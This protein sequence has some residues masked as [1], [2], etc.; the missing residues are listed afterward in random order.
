MLSMRIALAAIAV[1]MLSACSST[2]LASTWFAPDDPR[3]PMRNLA[4]FVALKDTDTARFI[5][6]ELSR[7]PPQGVA[8]TAGHT[9]AVNPGMPSDEARTA[10]A[11][12]GFEGAIVTRLVT[13][14]ERDVYHPPE[15]NFAGD[16][17][18][19]AP[20]YRSFWGYYPYAYATLVTPGYVS[21]ERR[22]IVET[23]LYRLP[24]GKP[25]WSAVT[26]S[27]N[28]AS[29]LVMINEVRAIATKQLRTAGLIPPATR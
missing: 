2:R 24:E 28:P 23:I 26:E 12:K 6:D 9:L 7:K 11:G 16:P 1:L 29:T 18:I 17:W 5:E 15:A 8:I 4:L 27:L 10:L 22:F 3:T 21:R 19:F 20:R 13:V 25:A 14:D